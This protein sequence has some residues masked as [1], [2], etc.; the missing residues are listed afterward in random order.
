MSL[1]IAALA[2]SKKILAHLQVID[3]PWGTLHLLATRGLLAL[4][5]VFLVL[6]WLPIA[7]KFL[8]SIL[9]AVIYYKSRF[10]D[11]QMSSCFGRVSTVVLNQV[12]LVVEHL[13][14]L[15]LE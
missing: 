4:S 7:L 8:L 3:L 11:I 9:E 15:T 2:L 12:L 5:V 1:H 13:L 14:T 10:V 6:S